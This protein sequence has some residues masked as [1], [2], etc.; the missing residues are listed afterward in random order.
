MKSKILLL[1]IVT[2]TFFGCKKDD[3]ESCSDGKLNQGEIK[4]D[5]GGPCP[6]CPVNTL[7][8]GNS[9]STFWPMALGNHWFLNGDNQNDVEIDIIDTVTYNSNKYYEHEENLGATYYLRPATNGDIMIYKSS[10]NTEH[11]FIPASPTT[12]Q[13]WNYPISFYTKRKVINT[14]ASL[15]TSSCSYSGLLQIQVYTSSG[16]A[17]TYYYKKGLG[18]V[19]TDQI[20]S[21]VIF[22]DLSE[23]TLK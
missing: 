5:C 21:G 17:A 1:A 12:N 23:V 11:L 8:D 14:N 20:W 3:K 6:A 15:T 19:R 2:I 10:D 7:C 9:S 22:S 16:P 13:E 18:M 4:V